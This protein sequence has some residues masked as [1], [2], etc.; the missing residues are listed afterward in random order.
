MEPVERNELDLLAVTPP[1]A[2]RNSLNPQEALRAVDI[3]ASFS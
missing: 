2:G 3:P 1:Y